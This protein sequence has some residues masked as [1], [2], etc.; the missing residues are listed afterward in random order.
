MGFLS[1]ASPRL[2]QSPIYSY[3]DI[4]HTFQ[5]ANL[6]NDSKKL[7]NIPKRYSP[8]KLLAKFQIEKDFSGCSQEKFFLAVSELKPFYP[9]RL[10]AK[11]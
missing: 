1:K 3:G 2:L 10:E 8:E 6:F 5:I 4:I 11:K 9:K 7:L